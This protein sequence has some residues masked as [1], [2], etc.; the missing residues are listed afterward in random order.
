M[1]TFAQKPKP[2]QH[3]TSAK[4]TIPVRSNSGQGRQV[5]TVLH[6]QRMLQTH[7]EELK[8]RARSTGAVSSRLGHDFS[9]IPIHSPAGGAVQTKLA[10]REP[11]DEY[12][13]EADRVSEQVMR[14]PE[15]LQL[16]RACACGGRCPMCQTE[17]H[18]Q[19]HER[20]QTKLAGSSVAGQ[21]ALPSIV[22]EVLSSPGQPLDPVTRAFMEP[23]FG[24]DF[25]QV[26]VYTDAKAAES[27]QAVNA[28]AYTVRRSVVFGSG[29]Y[30]PGT[31]TGKRLLA[32][33]LTHIVQ[34]R[35]S[36]D[37][38]QRQPKDPQAASGPGYVR[39]PHGGVLWVP[40]MAEWYRSTR[41]QS[42]F[43][44]GEAVGELVKT[45]VVG[46]VEYVV[47]LGRGVL[48]IGRYGKATVV[49]IWDPSEL[50]DLTSNDIAFIDLIY[51]IVTNPEKVLETIITGFAAAMAA[52]RELS[53]EQKQKGKQLAQEAAAEFG[54]KQ[55]G[56]WLVQKALITALVGPLMRRIVARVSSELAKKV[57]S[58]AKGA[59]LM[60]LSVLGLMEKAG[61]ASKRLKKRYPL[62]YNHLE[63][64]GL[65][66][67]WFLIE[68][69]EVELRRQIEAELGR[70]G[71]IGPVR[72][73]MVKLTYSSG[74]VER[75]R[76]VR[77]CTD[78]VLQFDPPG[79]AHMSAFKSIVFDGGTL[80]PVGSTAADRERFFKAVGKQPEA[81]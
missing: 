35:S 22:H 15:L 55:L 13:Q 69:H 10:V 41:P 51:R 26:R 16:Q 40:D 78:G 77:I 49:A 19:E 71:H 60:A 23:C 44:P 80:R 24:Q 46:G 2:T 64:E 5:S 54:Q 58:K 63:P 70:R 81:C 72:G 20:S 14:M 75:R 9:R 32:H 43:K 36:G 59:P 30:A 37:R 8:I 31:M 61:E 56:K 38:I 1:R 42:G 68:P 25:S 66:I 11:G 53:E 62:L 21:T 50:K 48:H 29:Q 18:D 76:V 57:V 45:V 47:D 67:A 6:L 39:H 28:L 27:A 73:E 34:Q 12:E 17:K 7:A 33:E 4:S 52:E 65:H 3:A 74:L 79:Q